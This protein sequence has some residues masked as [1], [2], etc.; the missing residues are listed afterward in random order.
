VFAIS[1]FRCRFTVDV[2]DCSQYRAADMLEVVKSRLPKQESMHRYLM[3][4]TVRYTRRLRSLDLYKCAMLDKID[5]DTGEL[6]GIWQ[7]YLG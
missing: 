5:V 3:L 1:T 6:H 7:D 2:H 4:L